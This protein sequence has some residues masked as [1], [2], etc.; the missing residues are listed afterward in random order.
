MESNLRD[1]VKQHSTDLLKMARALDENL[2]QSGLSAMQHLL[3]ASEF[4][5]SV[6]TRWSHLGS[7]ITEAE[8]ALRSSMVL[9]QRVSA[10]LDY[11]INKTWEHHSLLNA[12]SDSL[13][14]IAA[15]LGDLPVQLDQQLQLLNRS[16][17]AI[18]E[19]WNGHVMQPRAFL[20]EWFESIS[21]SALVKHLL[22]VNYQ[23][24][25][26]IITVVSQ[27]IPLCLG[28]YRACARL[29]AICKT[30][31]LFS[32]RLFAAFL[33]FLQLRLRKHVKPVGHVQPVGIAECW[34]PGP[35]R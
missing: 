10:S 26:M 32:K 23:Y 24:L 18:Q 34:I 13:P 2:Q 6:G 22:Q 8:G 1:I 30:L 25:D 20:A 4:Y 12:M 5:N 27:L 7:A 35:I 29:G 19:G 17:L 33:S 9:S 28:F 11:Q 21:I 31:A 3:T 15:L 16:A 14:H